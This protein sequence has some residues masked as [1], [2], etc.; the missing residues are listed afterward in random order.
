MANMDMQTDITNYLT[1]L[2]T[3]T[4]SVNVVNLSAVTGGSLFGQK[5]KWVTDITTA[6][7]D[8]VL[9]TFPGHY[10]GQFQVDTV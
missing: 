2:C 4:Y 1:Q 3:C 5:V 9:Y 7:M 10:M 8:P 6:V